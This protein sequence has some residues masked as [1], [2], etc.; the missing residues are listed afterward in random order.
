MSNCTFQG[1]PLAATIITN[2][3][4]RSLSFYCDALGYEV[5][6]K[7]EL[8]SVQKRTFGQHLSNY[9]LLG[10]DRGS[11]VR[12][13]I[14]SDDSALPIRHGARPWDE[15]MCVMEVGAKDVDLAYQNMIRHRFG[16]IT[17]P[18]EFSVTG[19]E[20]LGHVVMKAFGT[21]G[22]SGEQL[23]IT[24]ITH[25][26]GGTNLWEHR[27]DI[28]VY[29]PGNIVF[30]LGDRSVQ[31]FYNQVFGLQP[32]IDLVLDQEDSALI[33]GGPS[34]M[35][36]NMCL[37]GNGMYKSGMEQH[38]YQPLNPSYT[39]ETYPCEFS[40][41]GL[42]SACWS[43]SDLDAVPSKITNHGGSVLGE[44]LLPLRD[45]PSPRGLVYRGP[46]GEVIELAS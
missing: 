19:P 5:L 41:L 40:K 21:M 32:T 46:A 39:F 22:P 31:R 7:G 44:V 20:P 29:P 2:S 17:P 25:R 23:F 42:A 26:E 14:I 8:D 34:D 16:V 9:I 43:G 3:P 37:M 36:F 1:T 18:K 6:Q 15:G 28:N 30:S 38:V 45:D 27:K 35:S 33:M 4:G 11:I 10:H 13:L 24:Q 12:L